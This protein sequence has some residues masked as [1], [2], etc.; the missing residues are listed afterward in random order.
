[1]W[2]PDLL[3][4]ENYVCHL[5]VLRRDLANKLEGFN[6]DFD[7]SQDYDLILRAAEQAAHV[8]HIS[9]VL[10]H[11]R[12]RPGS[13]ASGIENKTYAIEAAR[14][15]LQDHCDRAG[16]GGRVVQGRIGGRFRV[17]YPIDTGTRVSIIIA[18]GGKVDVLR[19]NLESL[20]SKTL[21]AHFEVVI[22]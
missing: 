1:D 14:R 16:G 2:S 13:T 12:A 22:V 10:Y 19:T 17:R 6:P 15:A 8:H 7:G 18:A 9:K 3:L 5:L 21:Y 11:C 4:S 20:F